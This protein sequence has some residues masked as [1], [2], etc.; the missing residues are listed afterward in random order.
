MTKRALVI[1]GGGSLGAYSVGVIKALLEHGHKYDVVAGVSVGALIGTHIAMNKPDEQWSSYGTLE[2]IWTTQVKG[3]HSIYK[4]WAP[5]PLKYLWA[6]WKSSINT[7]RPLRDII[8]KE[9]SV[10]ALKSSG[11]E[12]EV[13]VVSLQSGQY[14]SINLTSVEENRNKAVDWI[15]AS[16]IF[17]ILFEPIEINGQQWVDGGVRNVAP[18]KD[19][20]K[21]NIT[22]MDVVLTGPR[23]GQILP[24]GKYNS[25]L[26]VGIRSA[27]LLSDEVFT[28]DVIN[29]C[30]KN[31]IEMNIFDPSE[32]LG[33]DGFTFDPA[34]I[35]MLIEKGYNETKE[36]LLK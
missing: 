11:V 17:P 26:E 25:A 27:E 13:G 33:V 28:G 5:G 10:E 8:E 32:P 34:T 36:K 19:V 9:V 6:L 35:K 31:N 18:I 4:P 1:S 20:L 23:N 21:Y 24:T 29:I 3:N 30:H 22:H 16:C 2:Q 14:K 12:F 7:M 15:W